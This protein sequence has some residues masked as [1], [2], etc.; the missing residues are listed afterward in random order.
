MSTLAGGPENDISCS[1]LK[2]NVIRHEVGET[3]SHWRLYVTAQDLSSNNVG[4]AA[5]KFVGLP[6]ISETQF[7][8]SLELMLQTKIGA[9]AE[10][11]RPH[12]LGPNYNEF[13]VFQG[14][15][16]WLPYNDCNLP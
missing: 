15:I 8:Q 14:Y 2:T 11:A 4:V 13:G 12:P 9:V 10:A 6:S 7:R 16:D 1:N 5:E 3:A